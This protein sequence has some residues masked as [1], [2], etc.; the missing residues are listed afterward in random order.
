LKGLHSTVSSWRKNINVIT[1]VFRVDECYWLLEFQVSLCHV[2][3]ITTLISS[4][5][6]ANALDNVMINVRYHDSIDSRLD[7]CI[8]INLNKAYLATTVMCLWRHGC[9]NMK[10]FFSDFRFILTTN[11]VFHT[12]VV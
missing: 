12:S 7:T 4:W 2:P 3:S 1:E 11:I 9:W 10:R 6:G 8:N 5:L